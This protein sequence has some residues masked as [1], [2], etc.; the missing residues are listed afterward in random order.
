MVVI[1]SHQAGAR[2]ETIRTRLARFMPRT[3]AT[4]WSVAWSSRTERADE[5]GSEDELSAAEHIG[6]YGAALS[7]ALAKVEI[8]PVG[9]RVIAVTQPVPGDGSP[10]ITLEIHAQIAVPGLGVEI[11]ESIARRVEPS[12]PVWT[13][14]ATEGRVRVVAVLD[15]ATLQDTPESTVGSPSSNRRPQPITAPASPLWS[16]RIRVPIPSMPKWLTP[17][18]GVLLALAVGVFTFVPHGALLPG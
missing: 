1:A 17:R 8:S 7:H 5:L 11:V 6:C 15:D 14:L 10:P 13:G 2:P 3:T 9:L 16:M 18:M 4:G 12:C